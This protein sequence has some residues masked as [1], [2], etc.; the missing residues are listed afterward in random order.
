MLTPWA[1]PSSPEPGGSAYAWSVYSDGS[2]NNNY[3]SNSY[4][5]RPALALD[6][7]LFVSVP[8]DASD[9]EGYTSDQL[10]DEI[11][12]RR[13]AKKEGAEG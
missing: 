2:Y 10:M 1:T 6:P 4:G 7:S 12:R 13:E 11:L 9:L 3:C 5:I 8:G